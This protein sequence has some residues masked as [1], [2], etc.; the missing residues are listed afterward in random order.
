MSVHC[1][2]PAADSEL[3]ALTDDELLV[4]YQEAQFA[5]EAA[6]FGSGSRV[7]TFARLLSMELAV[8]SRLGADHARL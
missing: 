7:E 8:S 3:G 5:Y 4:A 2:A 6:R 1:T